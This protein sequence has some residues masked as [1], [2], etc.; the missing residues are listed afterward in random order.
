[1]EEWLHSEQIQEALKPTLDKNY[2]D[3]DPVFNMTVDEDYDYRASGVSRNSFCNVYLD[4]IQFCISKN[5]LVSLIVYLWQI[6][7]C[8]V[9]Y[10]KCL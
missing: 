7:T 6:Q 9:K 2:A 1:M 5:K 4:W 8:T 10:A 3:L